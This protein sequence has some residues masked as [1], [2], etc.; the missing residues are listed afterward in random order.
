M[1]RDYHLIVPITITTLALT[2]SAC[3]SNGAKV[4]DI[5]DPPVEQVE[6]EG[7]IVLGESSFPEGIVTAPNGEKYVGG[8][9]DGIVYKA[10]QF[11]KSSEI[12][13]SNPDIRNVVGV[14]VSSDNRYLAFCDTDASTASQP[15]VRV[16]EIASQT[17]VSSHLLG[18]SGFCNDL[19]FHNG[20]LYITDS[21]QQAVFVIPDSRISVND[22]AVIFFTNSSWVENVN[23]PSFGAFGPNGIEAV[24]G[25][26]YVS[27]YSLGQ[28]WRINVSTAEGERLSTNAELFY[29]DGLYAESESSLL[30]IESGDLTR[31]NLATSPVSVTR[32]DLFDPNDIPTTLTVDNGFVFSPISQFE[33]LFPTITPADGDTLTSPHVAEVVALPMDSAGDIALGDSTFPEGIV[34]APDGA[35]YIGGLGD[36]LIYKVEPFSKESRVFYSDGTVRSI[37]GLEV[38]KN[39][40]YLAACDSDPV[41]GTFPRVRIIGIPDG[42]LIA[43]HELGTSGFC[44]DLTFH[45]NDLYITDSFQQQVF[46]I[47]DYHLGVENSVESFFTHSSWVPNESDPNFGIFGPN[48]IEVVGDDLYVALYSLGQ[49]WKI[50]INSESGE[51]LETSSALAYPDGLF[52]ESSSSLLAI[53]SGDVTRF[54]ISTSPVTVTR[55][56]LFAPTDIPTTLTVDNGYLTSPISQFEHFFPTLTPAA[57]DTLDI[58]H[59]AKVVDFRNR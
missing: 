4:G 5:V 58:P 56:D 25:D 34:S 40:N 16:I 22:S 21:F 50:D 24:G 11:S 14:E 52:M 46:L 8:F 26:L 47:P 38:N 1:R 48:G 33:H 35:K 30:S 20:S 41:G 31:L 57:G 17:Q 7:S 32:F 12:F 45:G 9:G 23:D 44:N 18:T 29:P 27:L 59:T 19:T 28:I 49:L 36:G 37:V 42:N 54:D 6:S 13:Y 15:R 55:L 39:N 3:S 2:L 43:T 10:N 53:E 51:L